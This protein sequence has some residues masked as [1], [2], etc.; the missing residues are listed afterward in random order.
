M[1]SWFE[2]LSESGLNDSETEIIDIKI[3]PVSSRVR[4]DTI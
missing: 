2:K 4:D 3:Y 1:A